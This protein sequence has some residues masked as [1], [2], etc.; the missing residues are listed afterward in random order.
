M[1]RSICSGRTNDAR[2]CTTGSLETATD[3]TIGYV[4]RLAAEKQVC[5]LAEL[6]DIAGTQL[7]VV[8]DGP[9]RPWLERRLPSATFTGM[10]GGHELATAFASLDVFVHTGEAET[11]C[12]TIQEAQASGVPVV[13]PAAGGPID[14]IQHGRTGLLY[15]PTDRESLRRTVQT[16]SND[17]ELRNS[18]A[19]R[20]RAQ[21]QSRSWASVVDELVHVHYSAVIAPDVRPLAA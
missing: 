19:G 15:D 4:G 18:M 8:G 17:P 11:F 12:Q 16:L 1:S 2:R 21:V 3:L 13:A 9:L 10:L 6:A 14:L 7:V 5:R 20:A